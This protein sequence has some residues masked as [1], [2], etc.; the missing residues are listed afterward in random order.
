MLH[1]VSER[2]RRGGWEVLGMLR[3][4][5]VTVCRRDG[6]RGSVYSDKTSHDGVKWV[7]VLPHMRILIIRSEATF[8]Q[9]VT[10]L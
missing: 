7:S 9:P 5:S 1:C 4:L 6:V 3:F 10:Q 8:I 2:F